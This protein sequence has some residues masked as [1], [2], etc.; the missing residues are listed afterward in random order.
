MILTRI[1]G[2]FL[3]A[4]LLSVSG[5]S[6]GGEHSEKV[7]TQKLI[8]YL[9]A[10]NSMESRFHQW[11]ED[12]KR[13]ALQDITGTMW[14]ERPGKFRWDTNEPYP[15]SIITN[16]ELLWI[17]DLDLEQVTEKKLDTH[18]GNTPA[19]LL[20]GDPAKIS[21]SF[22]VSA[23]EYEKTGEWR[24]DLVPTTEEALF[25]LLRVHFVKGKLRD[26]YLR[27]GLGQTTRIEFKSPKFNGKIK[28]DIFNFS[29][30]EGID[31]IRDM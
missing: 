10:M 31:V 15:Q 13:N 30:P 9:S 19:L 26:M 17:Y 21:E 22:S 23:Y 1:P 29:I 12:S 5:L 24:F 6:F 4:V 8:D 16:G 27:D 14:V 18:V 25:E 7:A 11:V 3:I 28:A 20:S 2:I